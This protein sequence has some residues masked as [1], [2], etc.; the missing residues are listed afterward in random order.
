MRLITV[1]TLL[2]GSLA[3]AAPYS[4]TSLLAKAVLAQASEEEEDD[5]EAPATTAPAAAA[6]T[7]TPAPAPAPVQGAVAPPSA[8]SSAES[9]KLVSGAPLFNPNVAVHIVEKKGFADVGKSEIV[10]YPVAAQANGKFT[11]HFGSALTGV[12]HLHENFGFQVSGQYNWFATESAFNGELIEKV[13]QEAQAASSLLLVW[14][15][16]AGVEVTPLYGKFA[17][18]SESLGHF[19]LVLNGGAGLGSTRHQLKPANTAGPASYGETGL[20]FMGS[21]GAGFRVQL[22]DSFALRLEVRDLVY[23]ARVDAVNGCDGVDL[24]AM[25]RALRAGQKVT[26]ASVTPSCQ[27]ETFDGVDQD[28]GHNRRDDVP[29]ALN[30]VRVPSSDVLNNVG[31]YA[32]FAFLF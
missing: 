11:Q 23:T 32:G 27:V 6:P 12:Y 2:L 9:Q 10:L 5:D 20:K 25:D 17:F 8:P 28:T 1:L 4:A 13:R 26:N 19:S 30:L 31:F 3:S 16:Q 15:G 29:L 21:L 24:A 7:P 22:G 14:G 18:Y